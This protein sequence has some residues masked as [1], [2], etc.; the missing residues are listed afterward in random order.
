[1]LFD[2]CINL[3]NKNSSIKITF[4]SFKKISLYHL[5]ITP[6]NH[7]ITFVISITIKY[8]LS[9]YFLYKRDNIICTHLC[10]ALIFLRFIYVDTHGCG[11][12]FEKYLV[13]FHYVN[14]PPCLY[15]YLSDYTTLYSAMPENFSPS[16]AC[17][18]LYCQSF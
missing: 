1:M 8:F 14:I 5:I 9:V 18:H 7:T 15:G 6:P 13:V 11:S 3:C 12:S 10:L 4:F 17:Q 16:Y 2:K